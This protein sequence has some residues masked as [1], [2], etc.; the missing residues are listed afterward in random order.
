MPAPGEIRER[1]I[2]ENDAKN[3]FHFF[4][5]QD[6]EKII[7]AIGDYPSHLRR[8]ASTQDAAKLIGTVPNLLAISWAKEWGVRPFSREWTQKCKERLKNDPNWR[9]LR[10]RY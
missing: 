1:V 4:K 8:K 9:S 2:Y 7:A 10:V 6:C 5:Q 3:T